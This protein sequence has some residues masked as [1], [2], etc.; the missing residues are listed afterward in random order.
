[1]PWAQPPLLLGA[2]PGFSLPQVTGASLQPAGTNHLGSC[3]CGWVP[4]SFSNLETPQHKDLVFLSSRRAGGDVG[5]LGPL[6]HRSL[7]RDLQPLNL[8]ANSFP[9]MF[10]PPPPR[11][12]IT[13]PLFPPPPA[14]PSC[15][16]DSL[17]FPKGLLLLCEAQNLPSGALP[18]PNHMPGL[19]SPAPQHT[20]LP[21]SR[22]SPLCS[23]PEISAWALQTFGAR[24]FLILEGPL[25]ASGIPPPSCPPNTS[26]GHWP[27][28]SRN[29]CPD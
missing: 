22:Y 20:P 29:Y 16:L 14:A 15:A 25:Q 8:Q 24:S 27:L 17:D 11:G 12:H 1:M 7:G 5:L 10:S 4:H 6:G 26:P 2:S 9:L 18:T 28:A 13:R 23:Q 3:F 19:P 21:A